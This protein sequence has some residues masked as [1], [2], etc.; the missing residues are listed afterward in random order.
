MDISPL[1]RFLE[2]IF[3]KLGDSGQVGE[4]P[5]RSDFVEEGLP[6]EDERAFEDAF[7]PVWTSPEGDIM[8]ARWKGKNAVVWWPYKEGTEVVEVLKIEMEGILCEKGPALYEFFT[9]A[10]L[11]FVM[12]DEFDRPGLRTDG[13]RLRV[14]VLGYQIVS[15]AFV[16][17]ELEQPQQQK[18]IA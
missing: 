16:P 7:V 5:E 9:P 13:K 10:L 17:G 11:Q 2:G 4:R 12:P 6:A 15:A 18:G 14:T 8:H 3:P 1:R